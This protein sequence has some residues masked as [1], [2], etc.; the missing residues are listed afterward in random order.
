MPWPFLSPLRHHRSLPFC[1][2]WVHSLVELAVAI[3]GAAATAAG[4]MDDPATR[5]AV[6]ARPVSASRTFI[7]SLPVL[8]FRK[9]LRSGER[10]HPGCN[11]GLVAVDDDRMAGIGRRTRSDGGFPQP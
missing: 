2:V 5:A 8:T 11:P 9:Q 1:I 4:A 6:A 7:S 10:D 3:P